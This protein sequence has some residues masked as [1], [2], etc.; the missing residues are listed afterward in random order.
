VVGAAEDRALIREEQGLKGL[1]ERNLDWRRI[2]GGDCGDRAGLVLSDATVE[3]ADGGVCGA[4]NVSGMRFNYTA[5]EVRVR[6]VRESF[7]DRSRGATR[8]I[9]K[10]RV[11]SHPQTPVE[12]EQ[13]A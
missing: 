7:C 10:L 13:T 2:A 5:V 9:V 6:G 8:S 11:Q 1:D 12:S 3:T 4:E